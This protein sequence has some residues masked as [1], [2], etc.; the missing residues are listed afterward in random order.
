MPLVYLDKP[1]LP[2]P[3]AL[4]LSDNADD[5]HDLPLAPPGPLCVKNIHDVRELLPY[6]LSVLFKMSI[7]TAQP[8]DLACV[9]TAWADFV[10]SLHDLAYQFTRLLIDEGWLESSD[11]EPHRYGDRMFVDGREVVWVDE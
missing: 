5:Y 7:D 6:Q 1:Q 4:K 8:D 11:A 2:V 9:V 3:A 10:R